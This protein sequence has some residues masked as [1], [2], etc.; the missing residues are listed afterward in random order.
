MDEMEDGDTNEDHQDKKMDERY[1]I[2]KKE[3]ISPVTYEQLGVIILLTLHHH[4]SILFG[5][6]LQISAA[7]VY[8]H[9]HSIS[10]SFAL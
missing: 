10:K 1:N 7:L 6:A 8:L 9:S 3:D 2:G 4:F 5:A